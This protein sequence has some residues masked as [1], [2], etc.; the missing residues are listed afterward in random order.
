[1]NTAKKE[2]SQLI[3]MDIVFRGNAILMNNLL[4]LEEL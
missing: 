3:I 1:M 2:G 4:R